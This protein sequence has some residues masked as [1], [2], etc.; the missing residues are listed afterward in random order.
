[1]KYIQVFG[2]NVIYVFGEPPYCAG[3]FTCLNFR[4]LSSACSDFRYLLLL[5]S[6]TLSSRFSCTMFQ[7]SQFSYVFGCNIICV[8]G[9]PP[10]CGDAFTCPNFRYLSSACSD[11]R[12]LL[13]LS[14]LCSE[15]HLKLGLVGVIIIIFE[16]EAEYIRKET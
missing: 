14:I 2:C 12:Y 9:E 5:P 16:I 6:S 10:Y 15:G 1:M 7:F 13:L 4:Y 3:S 8:V 11:F